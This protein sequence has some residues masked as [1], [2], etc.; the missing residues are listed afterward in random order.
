MCSFCWSSI[1][2]EKNFYRL[3][4]TP[5][6][7]VRLIGSSSPSSFLLLPN[8]H[9]STLIKVVIPSCTS[10]EG[11]ARAAMGELQAEEVEIF[12]EG[13]VCFEQRGVVTTRS[14]KYR[15]IA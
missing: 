2:F 11:T 3:L 1:S 9:K 13:G 15:T 12:D 8:M 5:S 7:L 6:S 10:T 4:F 14:G